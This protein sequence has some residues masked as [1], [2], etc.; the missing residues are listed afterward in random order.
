MVHVWET[1]FYHLLQNLY[2]LRHWDKCIH[3]YSPQTSHISTTRKQSPDSVGTSQRNQAGEVLRV[4]ALR[5]TVSI[6]LYPLEAG[7]SLGIKLKN[8]FCAQFA[9][10]YLL[11]VLV[12]KKCYQ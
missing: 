6:C 2:E 9:I 7:L 5:D 12:W 1:H 8:N 11:K 3:L 4:S 10:R